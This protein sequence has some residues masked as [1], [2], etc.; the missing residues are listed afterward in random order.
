MIPLATV[1]ASTSPA[2]SIAWNAAIIP[3]T[4]PRKPRRGATLVSVARMTSPLSSFE[5]SISP[6]ILDRFHDAVGPLVP[7]LQ[8]CVENI[9]GRRVGFAREFKGILDLLLSQKLVHLTED[10]PGCTALHEDV[11]ELP[12]DHYD[13]D[14]DTEPERPAHHA[15]VVPGL[16]HLLGEGEIRRFQHGNLKQYVE[17]GHQ[18]GQRFLPLLL[19][20]LVDGGRRASQRGINGVSGPKARSARLAIMYP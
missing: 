12:D 9:G 6:L 11:E 8:A 10:L 5:S 4:V 1:V 3:I 18:G 13:P 19:L 20:C 17:D 15:G 7:P 14:H 2:N 16:H